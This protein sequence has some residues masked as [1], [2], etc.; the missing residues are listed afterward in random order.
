MKL[1]LPGISFSLFILW[2][3]SQSTPTTDTGEAILAVASEEVPAAKE[4]PAAD[5]PPRYDLD[6]VMGK[7]EPAE[8]ADF[9]RIEARYAD[10]SDRYM[11][12]EA[13]EAFVRMHDAAAS[14]GV[15]LKIISAARSFQY[16]KGIWE[17]KWTG[18]RLVDGKDLSKTLPDPVARARKILEYSSMPG[19]SRHHWGTD[20]DINSL[21]NSYFGKGKG[22]KEYTWLKAHASEYGFCQVYTEFGE[23]RTTGYFAEKWHW[24][25]MPLAR[26]LTNLA[27]SELRDEMLQGFKGQEA[28]KGIGIVKN[29]VLGVDQE[30][31]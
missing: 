5:T 19:S 1:F 30:C 11:H 14:E 2:S 26:E 25:Y 21:E 29:Y 31:R 10:R 9:V 7:F 22:L 12:R 15:A 3:C 16:Q 4:A 28:T 20:I 27:E 24:S 13:Y 17:K 23:T 18:E 6:Y 8:H